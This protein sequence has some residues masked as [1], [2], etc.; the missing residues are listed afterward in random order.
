MLFVVCLLEFIAHEH[1]ILHR[2]ITTIL[3]SD[4]GETMGQISRIP[5]GCDEELMFK[6]TK[7]GCTR[8]LVKLHCLQK[9]LSNDFKKD[10]YHI[11]YRVCQFK[12]GSLK[13]WSRS[14]TVSIVSSLSGVSFKSRLIASTGLRQSLSVRANSSVKVFG[15]LKL[16]TGTLRGKR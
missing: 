15:A 2:K 10:I 4:S 13:T 11:C 14:S 9:A 8:K 3:M 6:D 5:R 1:D 7:F 16:L 12:K